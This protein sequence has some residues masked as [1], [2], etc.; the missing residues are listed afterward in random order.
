VRASITVKGCRLFAVIVGGVLSLDDVRLGGKCILYRVDVNSP[1]EP[2]TGAFLDD[3]RLRAILPTLRSMNNS[4]IVMIGHQSRPGKS[5]FTNMSQHA[6][7]IS[8]LLGKTVK[9]VSDIC[10]DEAI[11]AIGEL[12]IGEIL[13]LDNIRMHDDENSM[14]KASPEATASSE[15]VLKLA[16]YIDVYVTDAF[17]AAHRNSPSLTGFAE[18]VPCVAGRLMSTEVNCLQIAVNDPPRPYVA[19][20]G[21]TKCDDSLRVAKNLIDK[22]IVDTIPVVGVVGNLMLWASGI[23]IGELNKNFIRNA[24]GKIFESTWEMAVY[25]IKNHSEIF[26]LPIDVA[27]CID[28]KRVAKS[29]ENL[30]TEYPI[31]D[32]GI[33]TMMA[34][35]PLILDAGCIL[36]NGPASYFEKSGFSFGTIEILNMCCETS[37]VTIV[38]GGHT[39]ALVSNRGV[40]DQVTHNSTGGG[41]VLSLLS[42]EFMPV[43]DALERS[44]AKYATIL[45]SLETKNP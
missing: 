20:L 26:L 14:K 25:L 21:G 31:Y 12:N 22:G 2:S 30:P 11:K 10:G 35:R 43:I 29:I 24:H 19:V 32:I 1:L 5:D 40:A 7:R 37:A 17:A 6:D 41:S 3:S 4:K 23:D 44:K 38:G 18:V 36:W 34:M 15:I 9:F 39:S 33:A 27:I 42:G 45:D 13:F 16:P 28:D 8:R